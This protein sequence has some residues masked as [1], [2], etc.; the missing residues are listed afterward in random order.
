VQVAL[1][2]A[3]HR[4][5]RPAVQPLGSTLRIDKV[6]SLFNLYTILCIPMHNVAF[7]F[8]IFAPHACVGSDS[9][10]AVGA[11]VYY[12]YTDRLPPAESDRQ[13]L[14]PCPPRAAGSPESVSSPGR[15]TSGIGSI[16]EAELSSAAAM[17]LLTALVAAQH[18]QMGWGLPR[19]A[20]LLSEF[21]RRSL[22]LTSA[23][24]LERGAQALLEALTTPEQAQ[25][26]PPTP[27]PAATRRVAKARAELQTAVSSLWLAARTYCTRHQ[28]FYLAFPP[29]TTPE[30]GRFNLW[31]LEVPSRSA[32]ACDAA[33]LPAGELESKC[34]TAWL[35]VPEDKISALLPSL[36]APL[37]AR[38]QRRAVPGRIMACVVEVGPLRLLLG[39]TSAASGRWALDALPAFHAQSRVWGYVPSQHGPPN[40]LLFHSTHAAGDSVLVLG[41]CKEAAPGSYLAL[42]TPT[43]TWTRVQSAGRFLPR[44]PYKHAAALVNR[45]LYVYGG[46]DE[47]GVHGTLLA[48]EVDTQ[49]WTRVHPSGTPP[50]PLF[51]HS[52]TYAPS[53]NCLVLVGGMST[54]Q[55]NSRVFSLDLSSLEWTCHPLLSHAQAAVGSRIYHA[56]CFM[57]PGSAHS[58]EGKGAGTET[59]CVLVFGGLDSADELYRQQPNGTPA[60]TLF[61]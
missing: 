16:A 49:V 17:E 19:L 46:V 4:S 36:A 44:V 23:P 13:P 56:A 47:L 21:L 51:G 26:M 6:A 39:G 29:Q 58:T 5:G 24:T 28:L 61:S 59:G 25:H 34:S 8:V 45:V 2:Y 60:R 33:Q 15:P 38:S 35:T 1:R 37:V 3:F 18:R 30:C 57:P 32:K 48:L 41:G 52:L 40:G 43:M 50:P 54:L 42:H 7:V 14:T 9:G 20:E 10:S 22:S 31:S 55:F 11:I 27:R 53:A 12:L